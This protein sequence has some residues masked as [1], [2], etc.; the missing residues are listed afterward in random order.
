MS[1][2]FTPAY[3][4]QHRGNPA[5]QPSG[6]NTNDI[7]IHTK[8]ADNS[9]TLVVSKTYRGSA[10]VTSTPPG[11][12]EKCGFTCSAPFTVGTVVTL[13]ATKDPCVRFTGWSGDCTG[14]AKTCTLTMSAPKSVSAEFENTSSRRVIW[15]KR[16]FTLHDK[17]DWIFWGLLLLF[18]ASAYYFNRLVKFIAS[19]LNIS[20]HMV[21]IV[22]ILA[23]ILLSIFVYMTPAFAVFVFHAVAFILLSLGAWFASYKFKW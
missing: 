12:D 17:Y 21:W 3:G 9:V 8:E 10:I 16:W 23:E 7:W 18:L 22:L 2:S 19:K 4:Q 6:Q 20:P 1:L 15:F 5:N 14:S 11:I 13:T